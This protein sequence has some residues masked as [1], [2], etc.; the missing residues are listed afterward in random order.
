VQDSA[1]KV[2]KNIQTRIVVLD[3]TKNFDAE[4]FSKIYNNHLKDLD[5]SVLVNNVGMSGA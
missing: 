4:T 5:L 1:K 2:G 3:F